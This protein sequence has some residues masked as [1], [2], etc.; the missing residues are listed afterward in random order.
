MLE[1]RDIVRNNE[2]LWQFGIQ[3]F[4]NLLAL[5][6]VRHYSSLMLLHSSEAYKSRICST[7]YPVI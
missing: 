4:I 1:L 2:Q 6:H 7:M 5:A 3:L